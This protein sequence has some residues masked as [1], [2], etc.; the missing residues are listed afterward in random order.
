MVTVTGWPI[1]YIEE[2]CFGQAVELFQYWAKYPPVHL[3]IRSYL[4]IGAEREEV[5]MIEKAQAVKVLS[6]RSRAPKL[7][8]A[9]KLDQERFAALKEQAKKL[10]KE[11]HGR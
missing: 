5:N 4:G 8:T 6:G 2:M 1:E 3:M 11:P 10:K 7:S 9:P